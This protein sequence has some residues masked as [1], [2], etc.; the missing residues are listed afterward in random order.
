M[1]I[2][3]DNKFEVVCGVISCVHNRVGIC[4]ESDLISIDENGKCKNIWRLSDYISSPQK[5]GK[6]Q[7]RQ[8]TA[9]G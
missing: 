5:K 2:F 7:K 6:S 9:K 1:L 3:R 8:T 4:R